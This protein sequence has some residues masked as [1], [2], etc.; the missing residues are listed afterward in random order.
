[1]PPIMTVARMRT[2]NDRATDKSGE[3]AMAA[4]DDSQFHGEARAVTP[5]ASHIASS[6]RSRPRRNLGTFSPEDRD[7]ILTHL[8]EDKD[9]LDDLAER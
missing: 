2:V 5:V 8:E 1:M 6:A 4:M 7:L 9:L 3:D